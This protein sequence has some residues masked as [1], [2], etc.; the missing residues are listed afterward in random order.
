MEIYGLDK[1]TSSYI[2][3]GG[4]HDIITAL[5]DRLRQTRVVT[6]VVMPSNTTYFQDYPAEAER[7]NNLTVHQR[8][9]ELVMIETQNI[10]FLDALLDS[11]LEFD[12]ITVRVVQD[13]IR[14]R[15]LTK[16]EAKQ[17][18]ESYGFDYRV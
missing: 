2:V 18:R 3:V 7:L 8:E 9:G 14:I 13:T 15:S 16:Q 17:D 5:E 11:S 12:V 6:R 4:R 1:I 10:E